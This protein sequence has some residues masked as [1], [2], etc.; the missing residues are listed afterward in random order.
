MMEFWAFAEWSGEIA[1]RFPPPANTAIGGQSIANQRSTPHEPID[2][3]QTTNNSRRWQTQS[4]RTPQS[5]IIFC[6]LNWWAIPFDK[7]IIRPI[8]DENSQTELSIVN[9]PVQPNKHILGGNLGVR[10]MHWVMELAELSKI[11]WSDEESESVR[12]IVN[13]PSG[14]LSCDELPGSRYEPLD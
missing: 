13:C 4:G 5:V 14:E 3:H 12:I 6:R 8:L 2:S 11:E 9:C 10:S 1:K 7:S